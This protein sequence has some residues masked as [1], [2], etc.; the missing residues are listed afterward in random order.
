[1]KELNASDIMTSPVMTVNENRLVSEF[2][3]ML[4]EKGIHGM[5][6][7]DRHEN[8][9]GIATKTDLLI[10]ELMKEINSLYDQGMEDV[11]KSYQNADGWESFSDSN[12]TNVRSMTV[13]DIMVKNVITAE[14]DDAVWKI[15]RIMKDRK[16]NH[17]LITSGSSIKGI[18]TSRDII[19]LVADRNER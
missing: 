8:L 13:K 17:M 15:C 3:G 6:V 2:A 12:T 19:G 11:F 10:F 4:L 9:L 18:V 7:V 16:I 1:M 5:P 14:P